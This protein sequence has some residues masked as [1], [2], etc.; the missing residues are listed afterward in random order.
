MSKT[1]TPEANHNTENH[2]QEKSAPATSTRVHTPIVGREGTGVV[3]N[4]AGSNSERPYSTF[5]AREKW[6]IVNLAAFAAIFRCVA[7]INEAVSLMSDARIIFQPVLSP[8]TSTS[9]LS[10]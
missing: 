10:L 5:S 1:N 7:Y 2:G 6:I 3:S 4:Q 8:R 9:L